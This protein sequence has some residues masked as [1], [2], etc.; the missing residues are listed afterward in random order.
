MMHPEVVCPILSVVIPAYQAAGTIARTVESVLA[1]RDVPLEVIA[2]DDGSTDETFA[3]L[4]G[5]ATR[6]GRLVPV[7]QSN[8]GRSAARNKGVALARG[9]W[10][11]FVDSDDCLLSSASGLIAASLACA[12]ADAMV[13]GYQTEKDSDLL[14][15]VSLDV[16]LPGSY[17]PAQ[18]RAESLA[19]AM[20]WGG[21][22]A[23]VPQGGRFEQNACWGRMYRVELL[24]GLCANWPVGWAPFPPGLKFS[25]DRLFNI[26]YLRMLGSSRV[27][28]SERPLY[29]WD[30]GASRTVGVVRSDDARGLPIY[31]ERLAELRLAGLV[32]E[33]EEAAL[34][35]REVLLQ[36]RRATCNLGTATS[37]L[38][39]VWGQVSDAMRQM[40]RKLLEVPGGALSLGKAWRPA[41]W[42]LCH[43][44]ASAALRLY[45]GAY[46]VRG[47]LGKANAGQVGA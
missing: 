39:D 27:A 25:E 28:L 7:R 3:I 13:F 11:M 26:A 36:F 37:E 35:G 4:S 10:A 47:L 17:T 23:V 9:E 8:A 32:D 31:E 33:S 6:D 34:L 30:R 38:L 2:V 18:A 14:P 41:L 40:S 24:R 12:W 46:M 19:H 20:I 5:I 15:D 21:W 45:C 22:N 29:C 43:G 42:L 16:G 1:I 44:H